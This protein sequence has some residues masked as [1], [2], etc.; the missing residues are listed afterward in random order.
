MAQNIQGVFP[1]I[2]T[3]MIRDENNLKHGINYEILP[4]YLEHLVKG[5]IDGS[6]LTGA[7]GR[8][9]RVKDYQ[10]LKIQFDTGIILAPGTSYGKSY[11]DVQ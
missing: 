11:V 7:T 1:A 10:Q 6:V 8:E 2:V 4:K 9:A 5:K 3:P